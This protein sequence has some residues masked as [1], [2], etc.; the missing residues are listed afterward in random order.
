MKVKGGDS[1]R[2]RRDA[3]QARSCTGRDGDRRQPGHQSE[4]CAEDELGEE[5]VEGK[6]AVARGVAGSEEEVDGF[7]G[8]VPCMARLVDGN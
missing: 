5:L 3:V 7:A 8:K 4:P 2:G 6:G 1:Q